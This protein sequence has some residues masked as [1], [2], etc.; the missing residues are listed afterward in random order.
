MLL[1]PPE[2]RVVKTGKRFTRRRRLVL[3]AAAVVPFLLLSLGTALTK[4]PWCDEAWFASP[5]LD[6][7][8]NG[9]MGTQLL[10]PTGSFISVIHP[11][12]TLERIDQRTYWA[13]PLHF[14]VL[15]VWFKLF[16]F[17]LT[18]LRLPAM[19]WGLT[20]LAA[21]YAIVRRLG[22]PA[23]LAIFAVF[24]AGIDAAF[25]NSAADGR[26][27]MM[28][29]ALGYAAL[30][31]YLSLRE[32]RFSTAVVAGNFAAALGCVTHPNGV[33]AAAALLFTMI[34]LDRNRF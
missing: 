7:V 15:A 10:E 3:T 17:S 34:Y 33:L 18:I 12:V 13:A 4:R 5:A 28:C 9:R 21:W 32:R 26:M 11:G 16:G 25:V 29:A 1:Y 31:L 20:A 24:L 2:T 19:A 27:D 6:L 8:V 23:G 22:G 14:L 30:A